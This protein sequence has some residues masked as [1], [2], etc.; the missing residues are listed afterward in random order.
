MKNFGKNALSA[1][2]LALLGVWPTPASAQAGQTS[3]DTETVVVLGLRTEAAA[4]DS[5]VAV[6]VLADT[7]L[8]RRG[9]VFAAD[10]LASV[11]GVSVS[12]A[13]AWG[14]T[15]SVRIRGNASGQTL[16]LI[17]GVPVNDVASPGGAF[18]FSTLELF[19]VDRVEVLRGPQSAL[20]GGDAIGGVVSI[21]TAE[22]TRD[23]AWNGFA[24]AGSFETLR[25]G[26]S[27]GGGVDRL[28]GRL[29]G[30]WTASEG[31]SKADR[32]DGNTEADGLESANLTG[33]GALNVV[34]GVRLDG[35]FR[36]AVSEVQFDGFPP[37]AFVLADTDERQTSD[38]RSGRLALTSDV[39]GGRLQTTLEVAASALDRETF[40]GSA[41]TGGNAGERWLYRATARLALP[42]DQA[43]R[44]GIERDDTEADGESA[45]ASSVFGLYQVSPAP[46]VNLSGGLRYDEDD[47][48]GSETTGQA[49]ASWQAMD[50]LRLRASWGQGFKPPT[51][52]QTSFV[53]TFCGLS[54]PSRDLS[55]ETSEATDIGVDLRLGPVEVSLTG[56]DQETENLI[57]FDFARGYAN[58]SVAKQRGVEAS[59]SAS[60]T[61]WLEAKA[62]YANIQA[63]D[64]IGEPLPRVPEHS[65]GAELIFA[66][67]GPLMVSVAV[68]HNGRQADGFGPDVRSWTR[69]DIAARWR[70]RSG[71]ELYSRIENIF[72]ERY[73]QVGG[74]GTPGISGVLGVRVSG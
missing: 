45:E 38:E 1:G 6:T 26:A 37:P 57:D 63:E 44:V 30:S 53:C 15:A 50:W 29:A 64:A 52:F 28:R 35:S 17:D 10:A 68:R 8:E 25:A 21:V 11:A 27:L 14:G 36:W 61:S 71:V 74:Y 69:A 67:D 72:D 23:L 33:R 54:T 20:W 60:V 7:D 73:Q 62:T 32:R 66:P 3:A 48:Y 47:R 16:V 46:G 55:A 39:A 41:R 9:L 2:A 58:I 56:F 5:G 19:G 24:E 13:G 49:S 70:F 42:G 31:I 22:L 40:A 18:D 4:E 51:L 34:P 65:G 43:L 59:V 12:Q